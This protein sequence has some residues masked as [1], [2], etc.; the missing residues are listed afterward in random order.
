MPERLL[1]LVLCGLL[2]G[3]EL[4]GARQQPERAACQ[5]FST[6][7]PVATSSRATCQQA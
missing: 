2:F 4:L 6:L 7:A 3:D 5:S 1:D